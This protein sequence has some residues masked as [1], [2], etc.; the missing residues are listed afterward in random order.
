MKPKKRQNGISFFLFV[1]LVSCI[2]ANYMTSDNMFNPAMETEKTIVTPSRVEE[3]NEATTIFELSLENVDYNNNTLLFY[4]NHS[5]VFAYI[6][7]ELVYSLEAADSVFGRTPG[8]MWNRITLPPGTEFIRIEVTMIYPQ[9]SNQGVEFELGNSMNFYREVVDGCIWELSLAT[10]IIIVG[11]GLCAYWIILFRKTNK[12]KELL[13]LGCFAIIFGVWN[14]GETKFAVFMFDNRAFWSYLAFT[15][16][17]TMCLPA[18]FFF[19][20]FLELK[21]KYLHTVFGLYIALET[22]IAQTLHLTGVMGV[23]ETANYTMI[24]IVLILIYLFYGI[25]V[26]IVNKKNTRKITVNIIGMLILVVTAA[27]DMSSYYTNIQSAQKIAKVGFL[28]YAILLGLETTRTASE[29]LQEEQK[30][31]LIK[32]M[33]VKDMLTGCFNRNAYNEDVNELTSLEGVQVIGFD[34]NDLKKC[35]D[36]RGHLAGD[37]YISDAAHMICDI[38]ADLGKVYR[39]GGDE[40][41]VITHG[42]PET[43]FEK[44]MAKLKTAIGHYCVDNPDSGFGIA[45]GYATF[46]AAQDNGIEDVRHRSDILMYKNKKEMKA[47]H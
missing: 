36:T 47:E 13:Y 32:E 23:K 17:M 42:Q 22:L 26:C 35:N 38:F 29:R 24:N 39:I 40:F 4:T 2:L 41:C 15:C 28:I 8:A 7:D 11:I 16:L 37:K 34:L 45:C 43:E 44:R 19:R 30:M 46:D 14:F 1:F 18:L 12:Q 6:A 3:V 10:A 33:A 31:E 20:E 25:I 21:D 9:L 5:E 27:V